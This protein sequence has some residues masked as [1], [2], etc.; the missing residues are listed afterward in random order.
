MTRKIVSIL[1]ISNYS[2]C[3]F[4]LVGLIIIVATSRFI[5]AEESEIFSARYLSLANKLRCPTC[6]GL[7]VKDSEAGFS[8]SIKGKIIELIKNGKSDEEILTYFVQRYGEWILRIPTKDGFNLIL[9]LL[10]STGILVG[11]FWVF[12]RFKIIGKKSQNKVLVHL[13]SEEKKK[14]DMDLKRFEES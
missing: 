7:S 6:Q 12:F 2:R 4:L 1:H 14:I 5:L 11:F 8:N 10:P 3:F 9:W 13:T